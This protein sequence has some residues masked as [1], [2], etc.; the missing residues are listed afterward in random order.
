MDVLPLGI[1]GAMLSV[2]DLKFVD[3]VNS[4]DKRSDTLM[5]SVVPLKSMPRDVSSAMAVTDHTGC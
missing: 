1:L 3:G 5:T 2:F 4:R